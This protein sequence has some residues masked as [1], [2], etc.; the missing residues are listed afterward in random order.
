VKVFIKP[1]DYPTPVPCGKAISW[2]TTAVAPDSSKAK[3]FELFF[4]R[5]TALVF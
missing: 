1:S 5:L 3:G 4:S 2:N